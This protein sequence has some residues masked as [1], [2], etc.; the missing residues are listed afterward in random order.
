MRNGINCLQIITDQNIS[1]GSSR[2]LRKFRDSAPLTPHSL[3][4]LRVL[5]INE[6]HE[7][8]RET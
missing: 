2:F 1:F 8:F 7:A 4:L 3:S 6:Y 5:C